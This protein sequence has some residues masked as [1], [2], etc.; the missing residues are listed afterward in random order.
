MEIG[1][2]ACYINSEWFAS[3]LKSQGE[4]AKGI[5]SYLKQQNSRWGE[6]LSGMCENG[7]S[8]ERECH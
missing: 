8:Y 6:V 5:T 7:M 3:Q 4:I 2:A 1:T